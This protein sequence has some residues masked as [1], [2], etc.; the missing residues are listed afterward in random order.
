MWRSG[1]WADREVLWLTP[2]VPLDD[3][4]WERVRARV[5]QLSTLEHPALPL[6]VAELPGG[7]SIAF[8][9]IEGTPWS[10]RDDGPAALDALAALHALG[11]GHGGDVAAHIVKTA[12]VFTVRGAG[13]CDLFAPRQLTRA[14]S[15][16]RRLDEVT[17]ARREDVFAFAVAWLERS[18]AQ[19]L[20]GADTRRAL[21]RGALDRAVTP[22]ERLCPRLGPAEAAA[23]DRA[24]G[25]L[26]PSNASVLRAALVPAMVQDGEPDV[27]VAEP[28]LASTTPRARRSHLGRWAAVALLAASALVV[29]FSLVDRALGERVEGTGFRVRYTEDS[30]ALASRDAERVRRWRAPACDNATDCPSSMTCLEGVC[31]PD[32]FRYVPP[33]AFEVGSPPSEA[34]RR[35]EERRFPAVLQ[36]GL[37]VQHYEVT[38]AEWQARMGT[39]PSLLAACDDCP[40]DS[41]NWYEA[42]A[43]ANER[44][45]A[46]GLEACYDLIGCQGDLGGGCRELDA[47]M[48]HGCEG[49]Y[50]C[51]EVVFE[52]YGC[53]GYRLP[54][55]VEWERAARGGTAA[56]T[57]LGDLGADAETGLPARADAFS[58]AERVHFASEVSADGWPCEHLDAP[59]PPDGLCG[60][61][62]VG[63][64]APNPYGLYD[65]LGNAAEWTYDA[66]LGYPNGEV[67]DRAIDGDLTS[68]RI[69]RGGDW[70]H[71]WSRNR[72]A[73]RSPVAPRE[74]WLDIGFRL[75]RTAPS[76]RELRGR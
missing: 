34:G 54:T 38:R 35:R 69:V 58:S 72:A 49:G 46:E 1:A 43:F 14:L 36:R 8:P 22:A 40:V 50:S 67:V 11:V 63:S 55:E 29:L 47:R 68:D 7:R 56:A 64:G 27:E 18:G 23:L 30:L 20:E 52:G 57:W 12:G 48:E 71:H 60:P 45:S 24:R 28:V 59:R 15:H 75:V 4:T 13:V 76:A 41:V 21:R 74:R 3:A 32:G 37:Y 73:G 44:S 66:A 26:R 16:E 6:D 62:P 70:F 39:E 65:T 2:H 61:W 5:Q 9:L 53:E 31:A 17:E 51:R 33:G 42:L 10:K 19:W 25:P